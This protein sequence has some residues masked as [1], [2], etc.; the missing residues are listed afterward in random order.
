MAYV[1]LVDAATADREIRPTLEATEEKW[2]YLPEIVK[3]LAI[4]PPA[5][6]AEDGWTEAIMHGG[7]LDRRLKELVA[8]TVS[9]ANECPYCAVSHSYQATQHGAGSVEI[10]ACTLP[11]PDV[12]DLN[13]GERVALSFARRATLDMHSITGEDIEQLAE[14]FDRQEIVELVLVISSFQLYNTFVTLLGLDIEEELTELVGT[15]V[16]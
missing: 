11:T 1:D 12:A 15:R 13:P 8:T 6:A 2:G 4:H 10:E 5:L 3:A 9:E 16:S 7:Y 14:H